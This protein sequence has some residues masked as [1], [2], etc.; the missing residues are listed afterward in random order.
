L[1][2]LTDESRKLK[3]ESRNNFSFLLSA[4]VLRLSQ[5]LNYPGAP[6]HPFTEGELNAE[7]PRPHSPSPLC[8]R[9]ICID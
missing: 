8:E 2:Q 7:T 4:F 9:G 6:R 3:T 1:E 5:T